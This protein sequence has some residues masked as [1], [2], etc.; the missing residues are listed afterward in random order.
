M[1]QSANAVTTHA[2]PVESVFI[3]VNIKHWHYH[4]VHL[5]NHRFDRGI[6]LILGQNLFTCKFVYRDDECKRSQLTATADRLRKIHFLCFLIRLIEAF[7][8]PDKK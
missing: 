8:Q 6:R 7:L 4:P 1:N 5:V 3:S 2:Y